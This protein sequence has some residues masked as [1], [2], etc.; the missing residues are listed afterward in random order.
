MGGRSRARLG[1]VIRQLDRELVEWARQKYKKLR[2][3][4]RARHWVVAISRRSP[5]L[6][7]HWVVFRS[8]SLMG[9]G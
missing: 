4:I 2:R 1:S 5:E 8:G 6:F 9:A 7:A 3:H